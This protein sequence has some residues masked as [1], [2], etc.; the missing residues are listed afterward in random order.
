MSVLETTLLRLEERLAALRLDAHRIGDTLNVSHGQGPMAH[1]ANIDPAELVARLQGEPGGAHQRLIAGFAS[2]V[3]HVLLEPARSKADAWTFVESAGGITP[4][5]EADTF[6]L[7]ATAA[8]GEAPWVRPFIDDLVVSY[9]VHL[10]RG[11]RVLSEPQAQHWAVSA[12]RI[13]AGARSLLFHKT[14]ASK[15]TA[16]VGCRYVQALSHGDGYD[17]ARAL[18]FADAFYTE[19]GDECRFALPSQDL[20]LFVLHGGTDQVNELRLAAA[21]AY[22]AAEYPLSPR[23]FTF[24]LGKPVAAAC[25]EFEQ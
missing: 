25:D 4:N 7:G 17:A 5:I 22:A 23:L 24:D 8:S 12:D 15:P 14:R 6:I 1:K 13:T 18:V 9:I 19:I 21:Q 20:F 11:L 3:L 2:G 10:D 16:H